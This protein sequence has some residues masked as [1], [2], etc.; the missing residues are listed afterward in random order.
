MWDRSTTDILLL[1]PFLAKVLLSLSM[2]ESEDV[3]TMATNGEHILWNRQFVENIPVPER[4]GVRVHE[5]L[6]IL[7]GHHVRQGSR[8]HERWNAACDYE[9]NP[10]VLEAGYSLPQGALIDSRYD[11]MS[12]EEIYTKLPPSA[13][14]CCAWGKVEGAEGK[15]AQEVEES[16][17]RMVSSTQWGNLP[18]SLERKLKGAI[19][20]QRS[21]MSLI[22]PF[23]QQALEK[24]DDETWAPPSRVNKLLPSLMDKPTGHVVACVDTSGSIGPEVLDQFYS[25]LLGLLDAGQIDIIFGDCKVCEFVEDVASREDIPKSFKGG[26]GTD[27]RPLVTEASKRDPDVIIYLTDGYGDFGCPST[28]PTLW[29]MTTDVQAPWGHTVKL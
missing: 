9:I 22:A 21:M 23:V 1:S 18:A 2:I 3:E 13:E 7:L 12:A 8:E 15:N 20:P 4:D 19:E 26:G 14:A 24:G 10:M 6:H 29:L 5:C 16:W 25:C 11:G 17:K 28:V 27:F